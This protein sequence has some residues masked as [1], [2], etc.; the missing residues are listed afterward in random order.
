MAKKDNG[1]EYV[2]TPI[3]WNADGSNLADERLGDKIDRSML[4]S[5]ISVEKQESDDNSILNVYRTFGVLRDSYPS[6]AKGSFDYCSVSGA[7]ESLSVYQRSL[8]D[9]KILVLREN[10]DDRHPHR[11]H[12]RTHSNGGDR[13]DPGG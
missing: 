11:R 9:E 12:R 6:L 8:D 3:M 5:S 4:S 13:Q 2:R 7:P 1:D 10:G